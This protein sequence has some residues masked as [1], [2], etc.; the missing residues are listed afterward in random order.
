MRKIN[1]LFVAV[2]ALLAF[3]AC[4]KGKIASLELSRT[5]LY[6][7]GWN[8]PAQSVRYVATNAETVAVATITDGWSYEQDK[9]ACEIRIRPVG[10]E[11]GDNS[12]LSTKGMLTI[13]VIN[14][15]GDTSSY[16]IDLYIAE[17]VELDAD[18]A[19]NCY[20]V[21]TPNQAYTFDVKHKPNGEELDTRAVKLLWQSETVLVNNVDYTDGRVSFFV[22][23][24]SEDN[25]KVNESNA[26]IAAYNGDDMVLWSWHLW[27]TNNNPLNDTATYS[28]G[29]EFMTRNLGS[30]G[31][32]NGSTDIEK[33]HDSYGL[34]YQWGRKDPFPRPYYHDC[35]EATREARYERNGY[36]LDEFAYSVADGY[37]TLEF[38]TGNPMVYIINEEGDW[39]Q[40]PNSSL[41]SDDNKSVYD[42]CPAG[43]RVPTAKDLEVLTLADAE[44]NTSL[45]VARKQYGWHLTDGNGQKFF[46]SACGFVR[47]IDGKLQNM[48]HKLEVYPS[49]PEPWEGHYWTSSATT[50]GKAKSLYFDLTTTRVNIN[51]F[52][53]DYPDRRANGKQIRC[54]KE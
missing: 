5:A 30:Y 37:G 46:Y 22:S 2:L 26:V 31:S 4:N 7:A 36:L 20:I 38:A 48:N 52:D 9:N 14:K 8:A 47:Y 21:T 50:D 6:Y 17:V 29:K 28:N 33:I 27:V 11:S 23:E 45:D 1:S 32:S 40:T 10:S 39:L 42:P 12:S 44:D 53:A 15:S 19:A 43:W 51:K 13:N 49:T 54:V 41:W 35:S 34:Y 18:G 16:Y 24:S 25:T 3:G